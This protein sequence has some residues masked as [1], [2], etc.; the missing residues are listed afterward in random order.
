[1]FGLVSFLVL[2]AVPGRR[3]SARSRVF[4]MRKWAEA[5]SSCM[6][7]RQHFFT[8][9]SPEGLPQCVAWPEDPPGAQLWVSPRVAPPSPALITSLLRALSLEKAKNTEKP[10]NARDQDCSGR[11]LT[12]TTDTIRL[13]IDV[14]HTHDHNLGK[15]DPAC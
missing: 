2:R 5:I 15:E 13:Q 7:M 9:C 8:R 14:L 1:M 3:G 6:E 12:P 10:G 4:V 11:C